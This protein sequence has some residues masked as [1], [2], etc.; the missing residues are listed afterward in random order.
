MLALIGLAVS[1]SAL[2]TSGAEVPG[3]LSTASPC[4]VTDT[5]ALA[6]SGVI[7]AQLAAVRLGVAAVSSEYEPRMIR[8]TLA[9]NPRR[10]T[11]FAAKTTVVAAAV[12]AAAVPGVLLSILVGRAVLA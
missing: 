10:T 8:A 1:A 4:D 2:V 9:A 5:T 6:L 12:L 7:F 11:V 3:C